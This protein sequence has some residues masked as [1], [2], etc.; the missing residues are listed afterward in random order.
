MP[1]GREKR[2]IHAAGDFDTTKFF[3]VP[4]L[5]VM[6]QFTT[7]LAMMCILCRVS[8]VPAARQSCAQRG[9]VLLLGGTGYF[10]YI[11]A[12][13]VP[14]LE[15]FGAAGS[16][17]AAAPRALAAADV[18]KWFLFT[19]LVYSLAAVTGMQGWL[20]DSPGAVMDTTALAYVPPAPATDDLLVGLSSVPNAPATEVQIAQIVLASGGATPISV[21]DIYKETQRS[22]RIAD[23]PGETLRIDFGEYSGMKVS[24]IDG[25]TLAPQHFGDL[26]RGAR[27]AVNT[28]Y[29]V[30]PKAIVAPA[31]SLASDWVAA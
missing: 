7:P 6:E 1:L 15:L 29:G 14:T 12:A 18:G 8:A 16:V 10:G 22:H 28:T 13:A 9:T 31:P 2:F 30:A 19:G 27:V 4:S 25:S 11:S 21:P 20:N 26:V 17:A 5:S 24:A 23:L 3:R